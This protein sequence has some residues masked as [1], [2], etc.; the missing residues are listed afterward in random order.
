MIVWI[1]GAYGVGKTQTVH[2]LHRR[3]DDSHV[4]D[5]E[6]LGFALH[7]MLPASARGDFQ[8]LPQ[9]RSGVVDTLTQAASAVD[10]PVLVPLTLVNDD[11]FDEIVG[12]IRERGV[13]VEHFA[14]TARPETVRRRLVGRTP[15]VH[16]HPIAGDE[17]WALR[18]IDRCVAAL[19]RERYATRIPTDGRSI[20]DVVETIAGHLEWPLVRPRLGPVRRRMRR[21]AVSVRHIRL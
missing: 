3:I 18:Q 17:A 14:L 21:A 13:E 8:D 9:W 5:P 15:H 12:G 6:L 7:K 1:N 2:E 16:G 10:H 11:Y 4:A 19:Q 20:D